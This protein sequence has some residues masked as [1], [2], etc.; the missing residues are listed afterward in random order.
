MSAQ[1]GDFG[2]RGLGV[3]PSSRPAFQTKPSVTLSPLLKQ[4]GGIAIGAA[5]VVAVLGASSYSM[6]QMG[7]RL[8]QGFSEQKAGI[9][10]QPDLPL[11]SAAASAIQTCATVGN[12]DCR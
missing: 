10:P 6:K 12:K 5:I 3:P 8:G 2:R 4:I 7:K 11:A 1:N 9:A